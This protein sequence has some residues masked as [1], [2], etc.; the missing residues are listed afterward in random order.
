LAVIVVNAEFPVMARFPVNV[1]PALVIV[2]SFV[3]VKVP[4]VSGEAAVQLHSTDATRPTNKT[5]ATKNREQLRRRHIVFE[6][7]LRSPFDFFVPG[8]LA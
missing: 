8:R 6:I 4:Y 5:S 2:Q 3:H 1:T 7:R